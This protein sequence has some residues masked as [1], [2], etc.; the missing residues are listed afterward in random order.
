M[1]TNNSS[2]LPN[3]F[4]RTSRTARL[5]LSAAGTTGDHVRFPQAGDKFYIVDADTDAFINIKTDKT[6]MEGFQV[7]TG[8]DFAKTG[9]INFFESLEIE[10]L[11]AFAVVIIMFAGFGEYIDKRTTIVGNRLSSILPTIEPATMAFS[12]VGATDTIAAST[13]IALPGAPTTAQLRRKAI[14]VSNDDPATLLYVRTAAGVRVC[15]VQ[16][17]TEII[18]PI[19][20]ACQVQNP[21]ASIVSATVSEIWWMKPPGI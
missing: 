21:S 3:G 19:S 18:L 14:I 17:K 2:F 6:V 15:V 11:N 16:P 10:N 4:S 1:D 12:V 20:E 13:V 8:K 7:G 9:E 5:I